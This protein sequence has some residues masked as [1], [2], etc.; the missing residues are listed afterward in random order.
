MR[1]SPVQGRGARVE[2]ETLGCWPR[3]GQRRAWP[4]PPSGSAPWTGPSAACGRCCSRRR[5]GA[6]LSSQPATQP[7]LERRRARVMVDGPSGHGRR[8]DATSPLTG[9]VGLVAGATRGCGRAIAVELGALGATVY[10]SGRTTRGGRSEMDR[11][12]TIEG[13]AERVDAAAALSCGSPRSRRPSA[14]R[15]GP[16]RRG[17][18][19]RCGPRQ[20]PGRDGRLGRQPA[21]RPGRTDCPPRHAAERGGYARPSIATCS[22]QQTPASCATASTP[23]PSPHSSRPPTTAR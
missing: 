5:A 2:G 19:R 13:T 8:M 15:A 11:P 10:S 22:R 1:R 17:P 12:E 3:L 16:G 21:A 20:D 4:A 23:P 7:L 18:G 6:A 9:R 14:P